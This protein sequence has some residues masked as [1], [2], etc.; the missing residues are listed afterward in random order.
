MTIVKKL[1]L[2]VG[3]AIAGLV[4]LTV[5][6]AVSERQL[7]LEERAHGV[8]EAVETASGIFTHYYDLEK[9]GELSRA[10]AQR[11]ALQSVKKMRYDGS[12]YFWI[13][14]MD[15]RMIMH[16]IQS[17]LDDK[18]MSSHKDPKGKFLF[19][20]FVK[21]VRENGEGYVNYMWP[22]PGEAAP[23]DKASFVKGFTPWGWI[24]GSG[25]YMDSVD[26]AFRKRITSLLAGAAVLAALLLGSAFVIARSITRP[27]QEAVR[28]AEAVAAG[29]LSTRVEV[30]GNDETAKVLRA[31]QAMTDNLLRMISSVRNASDTIASASQ[32]I[33]A[34]NLD[35][36]ARTENQAASLE[37]TAS[38]MEEL[39]S[40]VK[41]NADN[42]RQANQLVISA[43]DVAV[44]SGAVMTQ[45][46][47]T[48]DSINQ[49]SRNI[50]DIIS[51][52]DSIAFQTNILALNAAVE[53]A[54][55][56]EQG[57]GFAVVASEV[58]SLAQRSSA[59]AKEIKDLIDASVESVEAGTRLVDQ[60]GATINELVGGISRVTDIIGEISAAGQEQTAG[61]EQINMAIV[62]MD[63]VTQ[64]NAALVEE[65]TAASA[66]MTDQAKELAEL[67]GVFKLQQGGATAAR[68]PS[69][70][71]KHGPGTPVALPQPA[72]NVRKLTR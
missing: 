17:N 3:S 54:R 19:L 57:R 62:Q 67:I 8:K 51:V 41:Q 15:A 33:T 10:E 63:H 38:S 16:P 59:A 14:D 44:K 29:D 42:A 55:A 18:D 60:A 48:M 69:L 49:S 66:S 6:F 58:R 52:I 70:E 1:W 64:Q 31:M 22:K 12:E 46:V 68:A 27:L 35:L 24:I 26:A 53:A 21:T 40:T 71:V 47:S 45:V 37:E 23:V 7:L 43:S 72:R 5:I 25:V 11:M 61:I 50:V 28:V 2:L 30:R 9:S 65:A 20:E 36:S 56:G 34:G 13:N 32:Q 39:T 4:L